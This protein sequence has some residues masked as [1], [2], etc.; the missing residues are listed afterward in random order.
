MG[1]ARDIAFNLLKGLGS[2]IE[3]G[4][5]I[6]KKIPWRAH[7]FERGANRAWYCHDHQPESDG[8]LDRLRAVKRIAP[9]Q[10]LGIAGPADVLSSAE[11]LL[12]TDELG[13]SMMPLYLDGQKLAAPTGLKASACD[14]VFEDKLRLSPQGART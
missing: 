9:R 8:W 12:A 7:L 13:A 5:A 1:T 2:R 3:V 6:D 11:V 4:Y 14:F 10:K